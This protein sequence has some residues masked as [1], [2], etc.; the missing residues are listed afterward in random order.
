MQQNDHENDCF[1]FYDTFL[2]TGFVEQSVLE[3]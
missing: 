2:C 1:L 3:D